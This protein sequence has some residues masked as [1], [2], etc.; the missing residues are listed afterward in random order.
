MP[1]DNTEPQDPILSTLIKADGLLSDESKW[2]QGPSF[3]LNSGHLISSRDGETPSENDACGYCMLGALDMAG[4][5]RTL[6]STICARY[7]DDKWGNWND[8]PST[9]F[10]D[11]KTLF[12]RA[13]SLRMAERDT[14]P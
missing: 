3:R 1:F 10:E 11:V 6:T 8:T 2:L 14:K 5:S 13:I 9:T 12:A 7:L 4:R